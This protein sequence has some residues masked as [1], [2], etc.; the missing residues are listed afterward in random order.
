MGAS[1]MKDASGS[2]VG[3]GRGAVV[4]NGP[5]CDRARLF[6]YIISTPRHRQLPRALANQQPAYNYTLSS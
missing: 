4:D 3:V 1:K 6:I 5:E 2:R